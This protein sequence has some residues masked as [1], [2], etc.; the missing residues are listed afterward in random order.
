MSPSRC[1]PQVRIS[2]SVYTEKHLIPEGN[3][4][5]PTRATLSEQLFSFIFLSKRGE[6]KR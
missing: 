3:G 1:L 2:G 5:P 6:L 4:H